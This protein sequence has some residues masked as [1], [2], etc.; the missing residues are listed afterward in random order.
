MNIFTAVCSQVD[1]HTQ[2][3]KTNPWPV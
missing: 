1:Q 2:M 3:H